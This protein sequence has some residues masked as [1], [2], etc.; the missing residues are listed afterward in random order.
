MAHR[1]F[2]SVS[3]VC[4]QCDVGFIVMLNVAKILL[5]VFSKM[6]ASEPHGIQNPE[7]SSPGHKKMKIQKSEHHEIEKMADGFHASM[8]PWHTHQKS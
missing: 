2:V 3:F 6:R 8:L 5:F 4:G 1:L 7:R